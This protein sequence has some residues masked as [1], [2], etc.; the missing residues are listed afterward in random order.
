MKEGGAWILEALPRLARG[1]GAD[2]VTNHV[3]TIACEPF[4]PRSLWLQCQ[5]NGTTKRSHL[6]ERDHR[7]QR[8]SFGSVQLI[9]TGRTACDCEET[10]ACSVYVKFHR[11]VV[12][13]CHAASLAAEKRC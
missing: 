13:W 4:A 7:L 8:D 9:G 5:H 12:S 3:R 10:V 2:S 11:A 1:G 6:A